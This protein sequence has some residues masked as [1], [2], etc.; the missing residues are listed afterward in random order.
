MPTWAAVALP[1]R[2][3]A[4]C[5]QNVDRRER[6]A[7]SLG[8]GPHSACFL[9]HASCDLCSKGRAGTSHA[10]DA[11]DMCRVRPCK[12]CACQRLVVFMRSCSRVLQCHD[13]KRG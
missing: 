3:A 13:M 6:G 12:F 5:C 8:V 9:K 2:R 11:T 7:L 10:R 4:L 1:P